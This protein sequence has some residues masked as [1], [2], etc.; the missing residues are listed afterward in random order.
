MKKLLLLITLVIV[1]CGEVEVDRQ[2][3]VS[4]L[5]TPNGT[6]VPLWLQYIDT[7]KRQATYD[8]FGL[9]F[10]IVESLDKRTGNESYVRSRISE[11]AYN[12][13][14]MGDAVTFLKMEDDGI[15]GNL[16]RCIKSAVVCMQ[17][18]NMACNCDSIEFPM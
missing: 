1:S 15:F 8:A 6:E 3:L 12:F 10:V 4:S 9:N 14:K 7:F 18:D 11:S 13:I 17:E 5:K 16:V 2:Y